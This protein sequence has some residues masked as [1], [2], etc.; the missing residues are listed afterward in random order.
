MTQPLFT[1]LEDI[2]RLREI[3]MRRE[4]TKPV[5]VCLVNQVEK[6]LREI[7]KLKAE[8]DDFARMVDRYTLGECARLEAQLK[9][10][11]DVIHSIS[12]HGCHHCSHEADL[13]LQR[14]EE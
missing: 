12:D 8:R 3:A 1:T 6:Q 14:I 9:E 13:F 2:P 4:F 11:T 5:R 7:E 10:A